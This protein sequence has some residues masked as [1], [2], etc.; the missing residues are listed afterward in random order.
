MT[1]GKGGGPEIFVGHSGRGGE[2]SHVDS[3]SRNSEVP[4]EIVVFCAARHPKHRAGA[5]AHGGRAAKKVPT[6]PLKGG[7]VPDPWESNHRSASQAGWDFSPRPYLDRRHQLEGIL[8][9]HRTP[10]CGAPTED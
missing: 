7:H 4:L 2:K 1:R 9:H 3:L 6:V 8:C 5:P 10:C